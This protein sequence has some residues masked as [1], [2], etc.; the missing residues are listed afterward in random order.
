[1][2]LG[3]HARKKCKKSVDRPSFDIYIY[4]FFFEL[5]FP[6]DFELMMPKGIFTAGRAVEGC[7]HFGLSFMEQRM[8]SGHIGK[9]SK[10]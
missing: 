8:R 5:R 3:C 6:F 4:I 9:S 10:P 7:S 1:M 2:G